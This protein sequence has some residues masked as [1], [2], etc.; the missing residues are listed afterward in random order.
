MT[1]PG[2]NSLSNYHIIGKIIFDKDYQ[3]G[4]RM[5]SFKVTSSEMQELFR[6]I[7]SVQVDSSQA[8]I[9]KSK[10]IEEEEIQIYK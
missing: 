1:A 3:I 5:K 6:Y 8:E 2:V 4:K 7:N 9:T 10:K